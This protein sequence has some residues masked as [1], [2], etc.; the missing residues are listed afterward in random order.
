MNRRK[1]IKNASFSATLIGI[2]PIISPI[3]SKPIT[4]KTIIFILRGVSY[5]DASVAFKKCTISTKFS[6]PIF[7]VVCTNKTYSHIEGLENLFEGTPI[8][9]KGI[10]KSQLQNRH[11]IA[12][13]LEDA[14]TNITT[15][16]T[17]IYLHHTE[18]CHS[19]KKMYMETLD[20]FFLELSNFFNPLKHKIIVSADIGRNEN[21]NNC[22]GKDHSNPTSLETF[23]LYFGENA[24]KLLLKSAPFY[25]NEVLKQVY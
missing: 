24:F 20:L 4:K 25:Q 15:E 14:F 16:T 3:L 8:K 11:T 22:G 10:L 13:I 1:F 19:S 5:V 2:S 21:E 9:N 18:I 6:S 7:K 17:I 23:A 12:H